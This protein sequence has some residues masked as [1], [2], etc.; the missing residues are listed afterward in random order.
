MPTMWVTLRG[1]G[2]PPTVCMAAQLL[3]AA[4]AVGLV[5]RAWLPGMA[6]RRWRNT[7]TCAL[8]LL[9]TPYGFVYDAIPAALA[10]ML[11]ARHSLRHGFARLEPVVLTGTW[12]W[13]LFFGYWIVGFGLPPIGAALLLGTALC[14]VWRIE[15]QQLRTVASQATT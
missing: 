13:P 2:A 7:L 1:W 14:V 8:P 6:D 9:A 3:S 11:L 15:Q 4:L 5:V 12:V 10:A